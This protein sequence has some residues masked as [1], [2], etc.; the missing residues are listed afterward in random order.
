MIK[1]YWNSLGTWSSS[2]HKDW[3]ILSLQSPWGTNICVFEVTVQLSHLVLQK[4][5]DRHPQPRHVQIWIWSTPVILPGLNFSPHL[6]NFQLKN[7]LH[8][9]VEKV[10]D[11]WTLQKHQQIIAGSQQFALDASSG[12]AQRRSMDP[13]TSPFLLQ[14]FWKWMVTGA[15]QAT[16]ENRIPIGSWKVMEPWKLPVEETT[17]Y[18]MWVWRRGFHKGSENNPGRQDKT[19]HAPWTKKQSA[20]CFWQSRPNSWICQVSHL[21]LLLYWPCP[22]N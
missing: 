3:T 9:A 12:P 16:L 1:A 10:K 19:S 5:R 8:I 22:Q 6:Y 18:G 4:A 2:Y 17:W 11:I 13:T 21:L 7:H 20:R 15:A 14:S